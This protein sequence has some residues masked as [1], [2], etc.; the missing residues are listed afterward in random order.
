MTVRFSL[1]E[2]LQTLFWGIYGFVEKDRL[3]YLYTPHSFTM[4]VG[5][6]MFGVYSVIM[7]TVLLNLLI[8]IMNNSYQIVAVTNPFCICQPSALASPDKLSVLIYSLI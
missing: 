7:I 2:T 3:E 1:F 4:F 6:T 5:L 8:A